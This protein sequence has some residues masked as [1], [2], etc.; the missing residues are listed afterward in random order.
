[1]EIGFIAEDVEK[2]DKRLVNYDKDNLPASLRY[3]EYT[4]ILTKAIQEQQ[5]QIEELKKELEQLQN[6]K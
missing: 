1:L 2:I 5:E 4:A 6:N 3:N